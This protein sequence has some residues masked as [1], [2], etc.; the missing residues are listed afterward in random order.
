MIE[1]GNM[2]PIDS[3]QDVSGLVDMIRDEIQILIVTN[4]KLWTPICKVGCGFWCHFILSLGLMHLIAIFQVWD[5]SFPSQII[6]ESLELLVKAWHCCEVVR[7]L[8]IEVKDTK[9]NIM[10]LVDHFPSKL[11]CPTAF[12]PMT[13]DSTLGLG[14]IQTSVENLEVA[15]FECWMPLGSHLTSPRLTSSILFFLSFFFSFL[16]IVLAK[17]R[18]VTGVVDVFWNRFFGR[19]I[20]KFMFGFCLVNL[21][22]TVTPVQPKDLMSNCKAT[23]PFSMVRVAVPTSHQMKRWQVIEVKW[24]K[25]LKCGLFDAC[26]FAT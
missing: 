20:F 4:L 1:N 7:K 9:T 24:L 14:E 23:T 17:E 25:W 8:S 18:Y 11:P 26:P 10:L 21:R 3:G 6:L 19:F 22:G 12:E 15:Q 13:K 5:W 16:M 2:S